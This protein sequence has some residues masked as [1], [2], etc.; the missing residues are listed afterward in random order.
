LPVNLFSSRS[1]S[2]RFQKSDPDPVKNRPDLQHWFTKAIHAAV[3]YVQ[4]YTAIQRF[5]Y[6]A[7]TTYLVPKIPSGMLTV[8]LSF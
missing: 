8:P 4:G 5:Y 7:D 1:W 3:Q 2:G 6:K